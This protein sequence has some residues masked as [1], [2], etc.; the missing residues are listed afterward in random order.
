MVMFNKGLIVFLFESNMSQ[1]NDV[2]NC[3]IMQSHWSELH[4]L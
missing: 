3:N 1:T 4:F 2:S